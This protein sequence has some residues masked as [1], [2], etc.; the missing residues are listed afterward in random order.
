MYESNCNNI[1]IDHIGT[2]TE[3]II[4]NN[5]PEN[6]ILLPK[7]ITEHNVITISNEK[8]VGIH[9]S[10]INGLK[11]AQGEYVV[12]L[13]QDDLI[14]PDF[15]KKQYESIGDQDAIVCN[16]DI[17]SGSFY[18]DSIKEAVK[19]DIYKKGENGI[20]SLGQMMIKRSSISPLTSRGIIRMKRR[21]VHCTKRAAFR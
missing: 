17:G 6:K 18:K 5:S 20:I 21:C 16:A 4:V 10:K 9:A 1:C 3:L 11:Q 2:V 7:K 12:F 14:C 13:D 19:T 8:N 15:L